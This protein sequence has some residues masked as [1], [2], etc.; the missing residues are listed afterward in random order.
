MGVTCLYMYIR[1]S[2]R[3]VHWLKGLS[4]I[5]QGEVT[6]Q[7]SKRLGHTTN[8]ATLHL[9]KLGQHHVH[10]KRYCSKHRMETGKAVGTASGTA[11]I[12]IINLISYKQ[13]RLYGASPEKG[14]DSRQHSAES[15]IIMLG[16]VETNVTSRRKRLHS[17]CHSDAD[18]EWGAG[19][20]VYRS[21]KRHLDRTLWALLRKQ[22]LVGTKQ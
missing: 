16:A 18:F 4:H 12:N 9:L 17:T 8:R 13:T 5:S 22:G 1:Q 3:K 7:K 10:N 14:H 15:Y 20:G 11:Q 6:S 2:S 19:S 21:P